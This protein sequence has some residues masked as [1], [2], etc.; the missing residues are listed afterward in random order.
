M[1]LAIDKITAKTNRY[2]IPEGDWC[3]IEDG[4]QQILAA[5]A[6]V[7][8]S[9][10]DSHT[11]HL[12]GSFAGQRASACDRC[13]ESVKQNLHGKFEYLITTMKEETPELRDFECSDEEANTL[14]LTEPEIDVDA[15]LR[16]QAYLALPLRTLCREDCKGICAGCGVGLNS[17]T[18]RCPS[19]NS[20]SPF[21]VLA[22]LSNK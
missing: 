17:D 13:G 14:Y 2:R 21:A 22:N 6:D 4:G 5:T 20:G 11:V 18:C 3:R 9:R 7:A 12:T 15:I 8:V 19:D 16:E 10:H 1:K